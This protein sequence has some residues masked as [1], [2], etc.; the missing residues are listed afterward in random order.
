VFDPIKRDE[1]I[2][3]IL[4]PVYKLVKATES[5][6]PSPPAPVSPHQLALL[7]IVFAL[8]AQK[9]LTL[10][11]QHPEANLY[12]HLCRAAL[13]LRSMFDSPEVSTV[14][15]IV[16][17]SMYIYFGGSTYTLDSSWSLGSLGFRLGQS[18]SGVLPFPAAV[19]NLVALLTG[20]SGFV[21]VSHP[22]H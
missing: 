20:R 7:Y 10:P 19:S 9:D 1:L 5:G 22:F 11:P 16:L 13:S 21:S 14:Q 2:D 8:G 12:Y 6:H 18:V 4:T 17:M 15:A 3:D